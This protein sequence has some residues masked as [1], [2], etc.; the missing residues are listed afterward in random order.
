MDVGSLRSF[1]QKEEEF[2]FICDEGCVSIS[3]YT[4][5]IVKVVMKKGERK[6]EVSSYAVVGPK[7]SVPIQ[8]MDHGDSLSLM[9]DQLVLRI[10]KS[11]FRLSFYHKNHLLL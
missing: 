7:E 4:P 6:K 11:P 8:W 1:Q 10:Q 3:F 9:G 5:E 2:S